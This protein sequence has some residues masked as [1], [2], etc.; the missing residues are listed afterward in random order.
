MVMIMAPKP[1]RLSSKS[2]TLATFTQAFL[3]IPNQ[4]GTNGRKEQR[5]REMDRAW[6]TPR[7]CQEVSETLVFNNHSYQDNSFLFVKSGGTSP[8][9]PSKHISWALSLHLYLQIHACSKNREADLLDW[10][11]DGAPLPANVQLGL[12]N[13]RYW[14]KSGRRKKLGNI[15]PISFSVVLAVAEAPGVRSLHRPSHH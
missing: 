5:E 15:F 13:E 8:P 1:V 9:S 2:C 3:G 11:L 12:A 10:P 7:E 14:F 6:T 4:G